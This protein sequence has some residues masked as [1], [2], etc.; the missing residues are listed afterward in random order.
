MGN[1][2]EDIKRRLFELQDEK[3]RE[4]HSK[5]MPETDPG[6]VIGVRT[7]QLRKLG[8]ELADM[9]EVQQFMEQLPHE[10]YEENNLQGF[11]I[12]GIR[13]Y[14][15]C[16]RRLE[17]FLLYIDNWATCDMISPKVFERNREDLIVHVKS[18][19]QSSHTYTIRFGIR[20]L[21]KHYLDDNCAEN[22]LEMVSSV[23]SEEY[24]VNMMIGWFFA[25]AL[26]KQYDRTL[27]YI[28]ERKLDIWTHNKAIQKAR[29]S[30]RVPEEHKEY[31]NTLKIR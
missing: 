27:P 9:P 23:R 25:E 28:E 11:V 6:S 22:S 12:E 13:D 17:E 4:F 7:P 24:Y 2:T 29:E 1:I 3:Y 8:K 21:M 26:T 31:L 18:W 15:E 20:M 10:Y 16:I 30:R 14:E 5:L 19:L